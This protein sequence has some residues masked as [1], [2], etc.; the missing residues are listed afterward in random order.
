MNLQISDL[1]PSKAWEITP[2][3]DVVYAALVIMLC[4]VIVVLYKKTINLELEHREMINTVHEVSK[5]TVR[6]LSEI[7]NKDDV[8]ITKITNMLDRILDKLN[9]Y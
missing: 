2:N 9:K 6:S 4:G 8:N 7:Q 5:E 3:S 1:D